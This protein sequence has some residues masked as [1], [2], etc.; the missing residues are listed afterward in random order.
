MAILVD[1]RDVGASRSDRVLFDGVSLTVSE[2]DRIGVVGINGTGKS[3]LLRVVAGIEEPERGRVTRARSAQVGVLEQEPRLAEGSVRDAVGSG[4]EADAALERLGMGALASTH[5]SRLSGGQEK[6]VALASVLARPADLL[7]LDEPT[8]HLDLV[9]VGWLEQLLLTGRGELVLVSHDRHLLERVTDKMVEIDRGRTYVHVGGYGSYLADRA[10]REERAATAE[11][12]RRNLARRE[13]E[14][15]RRGAPARTRKPGARVASA[16]A[17][18]GARPE[19]AARPSALELRAVTPR[20]GDK[21]IECTG[22]AFGHEEGTS[23][24]HDVDLV[25]GPRERLGVVGANGAGKST[26]LE[27]LAGRREPTAGTVE[28]GPTVVLGLYD[29]RG[30]ELDPSSRVQDVVA[31]PARRPGGPEDVALMER[32]WFTG[33]L[34]FARVGTLS[35][36][37][38]RRLQLLVVLARRP[39]VLL[40]D[41]PTND[42]DLD[43]LRA[44]EDFLDE[45]PGALVVVSHDRTFLERTTERLVA[46]RGSGVVEPVA[47]GVAA[48]VASHDRAGGPG[49]RSLHRDASRGRP[50]AGGTG[51]VPRPAPRPSPGA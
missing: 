11:A 35:G 19:A 14:W 32:F 49:G 48:W 43:T 9:G 27:L 26:L 12:T 3:T 25:V 45:W 17:L 7:V 39:N 34:P 46:V 42:F 50:P 6:R 28:T 5:V 20:L 1:L 38:R 8:N 15:L 10:A 24:L 22:V 40:L 16:L 47:G 23:V 29:Q 2:G 41:E 31:G 44:L 36:G 51:E 18:T 30:G 4:W 21:V 13:L 37:E 33:E